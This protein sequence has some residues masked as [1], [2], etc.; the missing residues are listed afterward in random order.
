M[1]GALSDGLSATF[2]GYL[3][4]DGSVGVRNHVLVVSIL[5]L[6]NRVA[7]RIA[8]SVAGTLLVETPYGR[9][10]YGADKT[11]HRAVLGGLCL[12][13]NVAAVLIVGA[14]RRAVDDIA[15]LAASGGKPV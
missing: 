2:M 5:G 11:L 9:G 15:A 6:V 13:P 1:G 7:A 14:D 8:D 3:R 10:Q 4:A 12:N